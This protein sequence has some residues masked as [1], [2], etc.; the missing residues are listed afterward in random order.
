MGYSS[1]IYSNPTWKLPKCSSMEE[2]VSS[3]IG[4][5][6]NSAHQGEWTMYDFLLQCGWTSHNIE[7]KDLDPKENTPYESLHKHK[8]WKQAKTNLSC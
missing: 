4:T 6:W 8:V 2:E 5:Q 1:T 3:G 7:P